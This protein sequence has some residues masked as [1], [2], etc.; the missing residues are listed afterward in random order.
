M[1]CTPIFTFGHEGI[2]G[3]FVRD[4]VVPARF[5]LSEAARDSVV[6]FSLLAFEACSAVGVG[7]TISLAPIEVRAV[8]ADVLKFGSVK[9]TV[10]PARFSLS[11]AARNSGVSF[12]QLAFEACLAVGVAVTISL[13]FTEVCA[14]RVDVLKWNIDG[15]TFTKNS[16]S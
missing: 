10:V 14:T 11:G 16:D 15:L 4:T 6:S 7:V 13:A 9:V 5:S 12:S 2:S 3:G 8:R 1:L